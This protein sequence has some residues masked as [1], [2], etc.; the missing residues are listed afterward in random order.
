MYDRLRV[1]VFKNE[2]EEDSIYMEKSIAGMSLLFDFLENN[3]T[4]YKV[5]GMALAVGNIMNGGTAKGRSDGFELTV[6]TKLNTT[7]DNS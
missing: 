4:L 3:S 5:L 1:W 6:M 7:K 2:W